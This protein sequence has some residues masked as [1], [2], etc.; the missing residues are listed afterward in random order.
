MTST[1]RA[2]P[3]A[4][5]RPPRSTRR[6]GVRALLVALVALLLAV[7]ALPAHA[8]GRAGLD[9]EMSVERD[10]TIRV[11]HT[12]TFEGEVP[13]EVTQ[14][15]ALRENILGDRYY[16]YRVSDV[17]ADGLEPQVSES[18]D[19]MTITLPTAG[20]TGEVS[21]SYVVRGATFGPDDQTTQI[22]WRVLQGLSVSITEVEGRATLPGLAE[23]F[24]CLSGPPD[25]ANPG[26][27]RFSAAGTEDFP[28]PEFGDGA[29]GEGEMVMLQVTMA[30]S[31]VAVTEQVD[32]RWT[33]GGAFSAAPLPLGLALGALLLGGLVIFVLHRRAG[34][35]AAAGNPIRVAE[36][37]PT[38][39]DQS[40]FALLTPIRPGQVGTVMD[41]RV[42]PID[43]TASLIDLAVRGHLRIEELPR[44]GEFARTD[45]MI[46]RRSDGDEAGL[47]DFERALLAAVS[48]AEGERGVR[49]SD[50]G[51]AIAAHIADVQSG[52]YDDVVSSGW[53]DHRPDSTRNVWGTA[54]VIALVG[55]VVVTGVLV[56]LTT[57]GLLG[58]ALVAL[59]LGLCFVGQEMPA[60]TS[61]GASLYAGL[62]QLREELTHQP[63]D[64]MPP[65]RELHELSEVLPYAIVLGGRD[66]WID[67]I[68]DTDDDAEADSTDLAW[69]HGPEHWHLSDLPESLKNFVTT[70]SGNLF[71]R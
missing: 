41:E 58:L 64:R 17:T 20:A 37:R 42:D 24:Q 60:R 21:W 34:R 10:G 50:I 51:P 2:I 6:V 15:I 36:F 68:V 14:R 33:L 22:R 12:L 30:R 44:T 16:S 61:A 26:V 46:V 55:A 45:W 1:P 38:G 43:V 70:V 66:R 23:D 54:G 40:E 8:E 29:R 19:A 52:L 27:C 59:A 53:F 63:T 13:D 67:A 28:Q 57:F 4:E 69:Y 31:A 7:P 32:R 9:V 65:G 56:A 11:D 62:V 18:A 39:A 35:D 49:V 3:P 48:P 47:A 25:A 5:S 71:T